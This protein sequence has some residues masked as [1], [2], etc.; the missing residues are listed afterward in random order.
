MVKKPVKWLGGK[1]FS[2]AFL[3]EQGRICFST[4]N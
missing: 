1:L 3:A 2:R 4:G